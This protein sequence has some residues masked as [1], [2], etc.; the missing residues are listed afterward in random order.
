VIASWLDDSCYRCGEAAEE[1]DRGVRI[2]DPCLREIN[3]TSNGTTAVQVPVRLRWEQNLDILCWRCMSA[4][5]PD[6]EN[7]DT[8]GLC[9]Q[10]RTE[11]QDR[12]E[13]V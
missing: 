6:P 8:I 2:C 10:C 3:G 4:E 11:L 12:K 7:P 1:N 5:I 13:S 9:T